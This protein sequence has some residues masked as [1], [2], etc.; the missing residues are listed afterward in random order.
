[1]IKRCFMV[2]AFMT[3]LALISLSINYFFSVGIWVYQVFALPGIW[4]LTFFSE[5]INFWP[6]LALLL[7]G[8][9]IL[10]AIAAYFAFYVLRW[11]KQFQ[12]HRTSAGR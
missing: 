3:A 10:T 1:M 2:A 4:F 7:S 6:K 5:E 9:F 11:I 12:Q 8:Q